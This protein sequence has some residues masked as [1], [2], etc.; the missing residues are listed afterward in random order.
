MIG[1]GFIV[2]WLGYTTV[3]Y[4]YCLIKG[5]DIT[6]GQL[7]NPAHVFTWPANP[8]QIPPNQVTPGGGTGAASNLAGGTGTTADTLTS[9]AAPGSSA[10]SGSSVGS[11]GSAKSASSIAKQVANSFPIIGNTNTPQENRNSLP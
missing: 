6:F 7:A 8:P 10:G 4:G 5:Y 1:L 2:S 9:S 11:G 3:L